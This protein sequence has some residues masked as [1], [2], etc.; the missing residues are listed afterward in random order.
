MK[1][2]TIPFFIYFILFIPALMLAGCASQKK[3]SRVK[4]SLTLHVLFD[5][6]KTTIKEKETA[7]LQKGIEFVKRY[8]GSRIEIAGHTDNMG[9]PQYN[10]S[11]SEKRAQA[12]RD[13]LIREGGVD[14]AKI[15]AV[16]HR[17]L[18]PVAPNKKPDGKDN[19]EGRAQ[20][21]RVEINILSD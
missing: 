13:Y 11:L 21:R 8:P 7:E 5:Y 17:D 14:P 19:P 20:N 1:R 10:Q 3:V 2:K 6:D 16:G 15:T 12:V 9:T 18:Y 4:D